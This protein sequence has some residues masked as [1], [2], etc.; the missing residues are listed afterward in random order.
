MVN[1]TTT[2]YETFNT[3]LLPNRETKYENDK[4]PPLV[5]NENDSRDDESDDEDNLQWEE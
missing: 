3:G 1:Q 4:L 5:Q 2:S